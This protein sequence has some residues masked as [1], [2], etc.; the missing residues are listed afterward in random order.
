[1]RFRMTRDRHLISNILDFWNRIIFNDLI[2]NTDGHL[3]NFSFLY[4]KNLAGLHLA[5]AYD[6]VSTTIYPGHT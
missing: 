3:K 5:P 1:M 6:I 2:G 4:D